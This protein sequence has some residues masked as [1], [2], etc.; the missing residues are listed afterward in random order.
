MKTLGDSV[1]TVRMSILH[2]NVRQQGGELVRVV[3]GEDGV[4]VHLPPHLLPA[5]QQ[6]VHGGE[7][8]VEGGVDGLL[9]WYVAMRSDKCI[10]EE[11]QDK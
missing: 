1:N 8:W 3:A 9:M 4:D 5:P 11:R 7:G 2:F 6:A 10:Q